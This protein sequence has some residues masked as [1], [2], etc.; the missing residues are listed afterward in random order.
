[1]ETPCVQVCVID[2]VSGFCV[3]CGRTGAEVGGWMGLTSG[4]RREVMA[5]LP[6][7]MRQMTSRGMRGQGQRQR[8]RA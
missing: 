3:G 5:G 7:R 2:P 1:M 4:E 6:E 8:T